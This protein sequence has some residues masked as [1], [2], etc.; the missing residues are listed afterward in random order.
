MPASF[1][2]KREARKALKHLPA[3]PPFGHLR[4]FNKAVIGNE[5][6]HF[7]LLRLL[8]FEK[9]SDELPERLTSSAQRASERK[10]PLKCNLISILGLQ[11]AL[12]SLVAQRLVK[13]SAVMDG[14]NACINHKWNAKQ[15]YNGEENAPRTTP[16]EINL[17]NNTIG[18]VKDYLI[19]EYACNIHYSK[20]HY[21]IAA[22]L[23]F[24]PPKNSPTPKWQVRRGFRMLRKS[25]PD[26]IKASS[27][28][29]EAKL[30]GKLPQYY[31]GELA[32]K[33]AYSDDLPF[34]ED[35]YKRLALVWDSPHYPGFKCL[36]NV[37]IG[38]SLTLQGAMY[39]G[40]VKDPPV[41]LAINNFRYHNFSALRGA[42]GE[43]WTTPEE[44]KYINDTLDLVIDCLKREHNLG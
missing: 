15:H 30:N 38:I 13:D 41:I 3:H 36:G 21:R 43:Y 29:Y 23:H 24:K 20:F 18:I 14:I 22:L 28:Q 5:L 39:E 27:S 16:G 35:K 11:F 37:I 12:E 9:R 34:H 8:K 42:K 33:R 1:V 7:F 26:E 44:I 25:G 19:R 17:I 32:R 2:T 40:L 31:L 10:S 6:P 4:D